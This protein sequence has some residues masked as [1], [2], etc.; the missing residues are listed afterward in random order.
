MPSLSGHLSISCRLSYRVIFLSPV[1]FHIGLPGVS[2]SR[3]IEAREYG[4][5]SLRGEDAE[6]GVRCDMARI[7]RTH[8]QEYRERTD[9][10]SDHE[11]VPST[12]DQE[13]GLEKAGARNKFMN[14]GPLE[15][16]LISTF[17]ILK[18]MHE[19][20]YIDFTTI[21]I[22]MFIILFYLRLKKDC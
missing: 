12:A 1:A 20:N 13:I 6:V 11:V 4:A 3:V 22:I 14:P 19:L 5:R 18:L 8:T 17:F 15:G 7:G 10:C 16:P 9:G 2:V 21:S